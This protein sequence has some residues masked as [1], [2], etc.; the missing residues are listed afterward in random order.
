MGEDADAEVGCTVVPAG[1]ATGLGGVKRC[2]ACETPNVPTI[3]A[4]AK[5]G[6]AKR[7]S[8]KTDT[9]AQFLQQVFGANT[10]TTLSLIHKVAKV[11]SS[12]GE[13]SSTRFSSPCTNLGE[14][15]VKIANGYI[16]HAINDPSTMLTGSPI[17]RCALAGSALAP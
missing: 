16:R 13:K 7:E 1:C 9:G 10:P 8:G 2:A 17:G 4:H 11:R 15:Q 3:K 14:N 12:A 6:A 5:A